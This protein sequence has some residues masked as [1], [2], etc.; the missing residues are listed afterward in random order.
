MTDISAVE[1]CF[2]ICARKQ[3]GFGLTISTYLQRR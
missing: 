3:I 1:M 2:I